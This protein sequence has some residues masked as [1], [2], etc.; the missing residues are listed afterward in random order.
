MSLGTIQH[1]FYMFGARVLNIFF[2][3]CQDRCALMCD[4]TAYDKIHY[5]Y[6][7]FVSSGSGILLPKH[8][9]IDALKY[10]CVGLKFIDT[11]VKH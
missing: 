6:Y 4:H 5:N 8:S 9:T 2:T 11:W 1:F 10:L 7:N 3:A